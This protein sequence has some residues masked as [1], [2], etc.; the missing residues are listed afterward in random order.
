[1]QLEQINRVSIL[2]VGCGGT[3]GY[4]V[5]KLA[6]L[7]MTLSAFKKELRV[8]YIL[9]DFDHIEEKNLYRQNFIQGDLG[10]NKADVCA[11]RY[12]SHFGVNIV[13]CSEKIEEPK[14]L[15]NL[16]SLQQNDGMYWS[17]N[18]LCIL[19]GAVDNNRARKIMQDLFQNWD[20][21]GYG[22]SLMYIDVGN[23]KFTGQVVTGYRHKEIILPPVGDVFPEALI[24]DPEEEPQNCALNAL[25]NPQN[26][27]ANDMAATLVFSILNVLLT[28]WELNT[29]II[30][31]NGKTQEIST[32]KIEG[33]E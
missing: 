3:G 13:S 4:I 27:G 30:N 24:D 5:P 1:M 17:P 9:N 21:F 7:L 28:N 31:F 25:Q 2:Q 26:I 19:I 15:K 10:K 23:G 18:A 16:F 11:I 12:G 32:R 22:H 20:G 6:R 33:G 8:S 14:Q 29:H